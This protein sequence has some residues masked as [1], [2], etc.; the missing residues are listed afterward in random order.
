MIQSSEYQLKEEAILRKVVEGTALFTG[1]RFFR[2]LVKNLAESLNVHGAWVT[3]YD[4]ANRRLRAQA[5]WLG[6]DWVDQY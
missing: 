3:E 4:E 2:A 1:N 5:F 6:S